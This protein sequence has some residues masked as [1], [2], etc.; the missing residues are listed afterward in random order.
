MARKIPSV[1]PTSTDIG[2]AHLATHPKCA[3][4]VSAL[5]VDWRAVPLLAARVAG[6]AAAHVRVEP[7]IAATNMSLDSSMMAPLQTLIGVQVK[8]M[9]HVPF[10]ERHLYW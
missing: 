9:W 7:A 1:V 2:P 5:T 10:L 8:M 3:V 4:L 6:Q